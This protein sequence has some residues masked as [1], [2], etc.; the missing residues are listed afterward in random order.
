[1]DANNGLGVPAAMDAMKLCVEKAKTIGCCF[2]GSKRRKSF[3]MGGNFLPDYAAQNG[4]IGIAMTN[5]PAALGSDRGKEKQFL[6]Q[7]R[8]AVSCAFWKI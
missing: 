4:M 6:G 8:F 5:G 3:G 2:C 7:I 1:M